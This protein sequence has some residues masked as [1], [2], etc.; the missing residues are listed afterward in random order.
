MTQLKAGDRAIYTDEQGNTIPVIILSAYGGQYRLV[1]EFTGNT[2][3]FDEDKVTPVSDT[4]EQ[5]PDPNQEFTF[6]ELSL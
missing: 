1:A 4:N 3:W 5:C 6:I 2:D